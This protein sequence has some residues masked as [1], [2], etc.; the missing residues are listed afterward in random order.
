MKK[1][2]RILIP[3][4]VLALI[5]GAFCIGAFAADGNEA[6]IGDTE[7]A[8]LGAAITAVNNGQAEGNTV[9]LLKDVQGVFNFSINKTLTVDLNGHSITNTETEKSKPVFAVNSSNVKLTFAGEGSITSSSRRC[10]PTR[11]TPIRSPSPCRR[12]TK[13]L[14]P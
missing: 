6:K 10:S 8:T 3:V 9:T 12:Q 4:L 5:V 7:Y 11:N 2:L 1:G 14:L 13:V